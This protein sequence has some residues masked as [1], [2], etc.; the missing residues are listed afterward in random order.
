MRK[1]SSKFD[2]I[3]V[4][5]FLFSLIFVLLSSSFALCALT[6][7][8]NYTTGSVEGGPFAA[9]FGTKLAQTFIASSSHNVSAV[10]LK[11][12]QQNIGFGGIASASIRSAETRTFD[13][14]DKDWDLDVPV[15]PILTSGFITADSITT[16]TAGLWYQI[17]FSSSVQLTAGKRYAVV[18]TSSGNPIRWKAAKT[19]A[20]GNAA[21]G[22]YTGVWDQADPE[23]DFLFQVWGDPAVVTGTVAT[24]NGTGAVVITP[25][26]GNLVAG[27]IEAVA[28]ED[29][30]QALQDTMPA[31]A[32]FPFGLLR[33][34]IDGLDNG[35]SVTVTLT[36]P[37]NLPAG[38]SYW[39]AQSSW[40][41]I[42]LG[43]NDGDNVITF[44]L[45]DGGT[46]DGDN[47]ENGEVDDDG[48][49][50]VGG[51]S[52]DTIPTLSEWGAMMLA[53]LIVGSAVWFIRRKRRV[54]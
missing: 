8:E 26:A 5:S 39:K 30:P 38:S 33:F 1:V 37:D 47:T 15:G 7:Y 51:P 21:A 6:Q 28:E 16:S 43:S 27:S 9:G 18:L 44:T 20:N 42:P 46:G 49:P 53:L 50:G 4:S 48:G 52:G 31:S 29:L 54:V 36:L 23:Y 24:A 13:I 17:N 35:G 14:D 40:V 19:Y 10:K 11:M 2:R 41:R 25:S 45:V 22:N 34:K 12:Y 3:A 32:T